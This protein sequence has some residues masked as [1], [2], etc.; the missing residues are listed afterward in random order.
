MSEETLSGRVRLDPL[1]LLPLLSATAWVLAAFTAFPRGRRWTPTQTAFTLFASL[2]GLWALVDAL[3]LQTTDPALA[4]V[5][6]R[7][8]DAVASF[9]ALF[10]LCFAKWA[11][12][13]RMFGDVLLLVPVVVGIAFNWI[14]VAGIAMEPWGPRAVRTLPWYAI[15][16]VQCLA[17]A[18]ASLAFLAA[19]LRVLL[20]EDRALGL[21]GVSVIVAGG[22]GLILGIPTNIAI[23]LG[24]ARVPG[25]FSSLLLIPGIALLLP[26]L[27]A[28]LPRARV[29]HALR[30]LVLSFDRDILSAALVKD[31]GTVLGLAMQPPRDPRQFDL[32]EVMVTIQQFLLVSPRGPPGRTYAVPVGDTTFLFRS[33][34]GV[35]LVVAVRGRDHDFLRSAVDE[36][37]VLF[38]TVPHLLSSAR[39]GSVPAMGTIVAVLKAFVAGAT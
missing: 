13:G 38:E 17:Y 23:G 31:D 6:V 10:L 29:T 21:R 11:T 18:L 28:P 35:T 37:F 25:P 14:S 4:S 12:R 5:V 26:A 7:L 39:E 16:F 15:W 30:R 19:G 36:A 34:P 8:R 9:S 20:R 1:Y 27:Y 3:L 22:L 2:L 24:G 32:P 33:G